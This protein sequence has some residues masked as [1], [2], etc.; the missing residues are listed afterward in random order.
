M[1]AFSRIA[2]ALGVDVEG[3][4]S[5]QSFGRIVKEGGVIAELQLIYEER[6]ATSATFSSDGTSHKNIQYESRHVVFVMADCIV[7]RFLGITTATNHTSEEQL[8]GL[9]WVVKDLHDVWNRSPKG[10]KNLVDWREFFVM[11]KAMNSDHAKDQLKL[12]AIIEALKKL[13][14]HEL[15]GEQIILGMP[16]MDQ[17]EMLTRVGQQAI[18]NAGGAERW[19]G[20]SEVEQQ[21]QTKN[22]Y[23]QMSAKLGQKDFDSLLVAEKDIVD[24]FV[25]LGCGMHKEMNSVK[26]GNTAMM[27]YWLENNLTPPISLPNKDNAATL[28]LTPKDS[29]AQSRAKKITQ[30]GGVKAARL[31]GAIFNHKD[32][33]KGQHNVYKAFFMERLGYVIDFP[34]TSSIHYQ[35]YCN[36]AAE[37]IVHLPLYIEFLELFRDKKDSMTWTNIEQNLYNTLHDLAT[38]A[39]LAVLAAYGEIISIPFLRRIHWDPNENALTLGPY[40]AHV[41]EHYRS[42]IDNPELFLADN[43]GYALANLNGQPWERPEVIYAIHKMKHSL[44][45]FRSLLVS[46]FE[47]SLETWER[48]TVEFSLGGCIANATDEQRRAAHC[49]PTNDLNE[50]KLGVKQKRAQRAQ[51]EMIDHFNARV[52]HRSNGTGDFK[53]KTPAMNTAPSLQYIRLETRCRDASGSAK[54]QKLQQAA[55]DTKKAADQVVKKVVRDKKKLTQ[56]LQKDEV[57]KDVVP[58]LVVDEML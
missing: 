45:S 25:R 37:L 13:F 44:L 12:V 33:K 58:V 5:L 17:L 47:G 56:T 26:G 16:L 52:M 24:F 38:L 57:M 31:A 53:D 14:E 2:E 42:I 43:T 36:A 21:L 49:P 19:H 51:N 7:T 1:P 50:S 3:E 22:T 15:R 46:F 28:K 10:C 8:A 35:L 40:Y 20:L 54:A 39:E 4:A 29:D 6:E 30:C 32:D 34:D 9:K 48:F 27:Q 18:D 23:S 55:Y 41:K 11:L